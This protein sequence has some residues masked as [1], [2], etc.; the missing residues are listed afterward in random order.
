M[1]PIFHYLTLACV[2]LAVNVI[3]AFMPPTWVVLAFYYLHY[4]M[5]LIPVVIIGAICATVGRIVL[6]WLSNRYFRRF[7]PARQREN[8]TVL[9]DH[10]LKDKKLTIPVVLTY[11]FLPISSNQM[12]IAAGIANADIKIIAFS[13]FVGRLMSYTFWVS[14]AHRVTDRLE[15]VFNRHYSNTRALIFELASFGILYLISVI[16]W[17]AIF[18]NRSK[19][20]SREGSVPG[21][22]SRKG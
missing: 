4:K 13:F 8:L 7:I 9:A 12:F 21:S 18:K 10:L 22:D 3:P 15:N 19:T 16:D 1:V 20:I 14:A 2:V 5:V 17:K 6:A 11:A